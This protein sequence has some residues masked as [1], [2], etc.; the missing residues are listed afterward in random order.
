MRDI[1]LTRSYFY[2]D[3][4]LNTELHFY[5]HHVIIHFQSN[6]FLLTPPEKG[7]LKNTLLIADGPRWRKLSF[8]WLDEIT[9]IFK[10][11]SFTPQTKS[12]MLAQK[13]SLKMIHQ[14]GTDVDY[15]LP[16][17]GSLVEKTLITNNTVLTCNHRGSQVTHSSGHWLTVNYHGEVEY[18]L[19]RFNQ[20]IKCL[21]NPL[22]NFTENGKV[23]QH[24]SGLDFITLAAMMNSHYSFNQMNDFQRVQKSDSDRYL[25]RHHHVLDLA[26][27]LL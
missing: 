15:S 13:R 2:Q 1:E 24:N 27:N 12:A 17:L 16:R 26:A 25:A 21:G 23:N 4:I 22:K 6:V 5:I 20:S 8:V 3:E 10:V 14:N 7:K 9:S 19:R 11:L 18:G